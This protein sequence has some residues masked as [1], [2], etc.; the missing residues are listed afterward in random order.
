MSNNVSEKLR[1][2]ENILSGDKN[3]AKMYDDLPEEKKQIILEAVVKGK[4]DI[5]NLTKA[6]A[7]LNKTE[8]EL[9]ETHES[10]VSKFFTLATATNASI[11]PIAEAIKSYN[12]YAVSLERIGSSSQLGVSGLKNMRSELSLIKRDMGE[13]SKVSTQLFQQGF[14]S[15]KIKSVF[16]DLRAT[17]GDQALQM[18][19]ELANILQKVP[20]LRAKTNKNAGPGEFMNMM[21]TGTYD[22]YLQLKRGGLFGGQKR[23][24]EAAGKQNLVKDVAATVEL[25]KDAGSSMIPAE[26]LA[27]QQLLGETT[28][29]SGT[30]SQ[31][32]MALR[33]QSGIGVVKAGLNT[34]LG[35]TIGKGAVSGVRALGQR[36]MGGLATAAMGTGLHGTAGALTAGAATGGTT[37][38]GALLA[39]APLAINEVGS[40]GARALGYN[41]WAD[42]YSMGGQIG[43]AVYGDTEDKRTREEVKEDAGITALTQGKDRYAKVQSD[44]QSGNK[45]SETKKSMGFSSMRLSSMSDDL[46]GIKAGSKSIDEAIDIK[47]KQTIKRLEEDKKTTEN[48]IKYLKSLSKK[49]PL[50]DIQKEL[51]AQAEDTILMIDEGFSNL[52][53]QRLDLSIEKMRQEFANISRYGG[54][55]RK[56]LGL[57]ASAVSGEIKA[58]EATRKGG[59]FG[60]F[61]L[62]RTANIESAEQELKNTRLGVSNQEGTVGK[63]R[64]GLQ[65]ADANYKQ[66][67]YNDKILGTNEAEGAGKARAEASQ[68]LTLAEEELIRQR[69]QEK[70]KVEALISAIDDSR[71]WDKLRSMIE[72]TDSVLAKTTEN[73]RMM[74]GSWSSLE[75]PM[76]K[77]IEKAKERVK[78]AED[79]FATKAGTTGFEKG[80]EKYVALETNVQKLKLDV[81]SKEFMMLK[82]KK[83]TL[84]AEHE[85][86]S[87]IMKEQSDFLAEMGGHFSDVLAMKAQAFEED[88]KAIDH[89]KDWIETSGVTGLQKERAISDLKKKEMELAK[90]TIGFQKSVYEKF[91]GFAFGALSD[92]GYKT[93]RMDASVLMGVDKTRTKNRSGNFIG[94]ND[95]DA[96]RDDLS[97]LNAMGGPKSDFEAVNAVQDAKK[98]AESSAESSP[99]ESAKKSSENIKTGGEMILEAAKLFAG[100]KVTG[101][102]SSPNGS[103]VMAEGVKKGLEN[104]QKTSAGNGGGNV[105]VINSGGTKVPAIG[106]VGATSSKTK[107]DKAESLEK[108]RAKADEIKEEKTKASNSQRE[109]EDK[110]QSDEKNA[111]V[112]SIQKAKAKIDAEIKKTEEY[113]AKNKDGSLKGYL[114]SSGSSSHLEELKKKSSSLG[115]DAE[116][117]ESKYFKLKT[118][119]DSRRE[120]EDKQ[121]SRTILTK[122]TGGSGVGSMG[123]GGMTEFAST[124]RAAIGINRNI[125]GMGGSASRSS[126]APRLGEGGRGIYEK[127][128]ITLKASHNLNKLTDLNEKQR[129]TRASH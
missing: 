83:D 44:I 118:E 69:E 32:L 106:V 99:E 90:N 9:K 85:V 79:E 46:S 76:Q 66:A 92:K 50:T 73:I 103:A 77:Q 54:D 80:T 23:T 65:E 59:E 28:K 8:K 98:T 120:K 109:R 107:E 94:K 115:K 63:K 128:E 72:M 105:P 117:A 61:K 19:G 58:Q 124:G 125:T 84:I 93:G 40:W 43:K 13:F 75:A 14:D 56:T 1:K 22:S 114:N 70:S 64:K 60:A 10:L 122:L 42:K 36:A 26:L 21:D 123:M 89:Q 49:A 45:Y 108:F 3:L 55:S 71:A 68:E 31:I 39:A 37:L 24:S 62:A 95:V 20:T 52:A 51:L 7:N 96:N 86:R 6:M 113:Y 18:A 101:N 91:V 111:K 74:D 30:V 121:N 53:T 87:N 126:G 2:F 5:E 11:S 129:V 16:K 38:G 127:M 88:R 116:G 41:K 82:E 112:G 57:K 102:P 81:T 4:V 17:F 29:I 97:L 119:R 48:S 33:V 34:A 27:T 104:W 78:A 25:V 35:G 67:L 100:G 110:Y 47:Q 12:S 15:N